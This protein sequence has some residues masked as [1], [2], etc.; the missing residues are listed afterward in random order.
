[1]MAVLN[2]FQEK[3]SEVLRQLETTLEF[4]YSCIATMKQTTAE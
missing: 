2:T 4:L 3:P 1:M